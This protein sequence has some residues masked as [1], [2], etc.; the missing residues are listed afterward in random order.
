M[1]YDIS[2]FFGI[3]ERFHTNVPIGD[4]F[5][6]CDST[7]AVQVLLYGRR[8]SYHVNFLGDFSFY[9]LVDLLNCVSYIDDSACCLT[10]VACFDNLI[11]DDLYE[12]V[13]LFGVI[14]LRMQ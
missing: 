13:D 3:V 2:H 4:E 10:G 1:L 7:R 12:L 11:F 9:P 5:Y 14:Q 8:L 6:L